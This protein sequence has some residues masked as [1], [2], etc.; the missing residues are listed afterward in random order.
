MVII[1]LEKAPFDQ[2]KSYTIPTPL[3]SKRIMQ[4]DHKRAF[5]TLRPKLAYLFIHLV[6]KS[7]NWGPGDQILFSNLFNSSLTNSYE[8]GHKHVTRIDESNS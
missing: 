3:G 6:D 2:A 4:Q 8:L 5:S 7:S 1:G